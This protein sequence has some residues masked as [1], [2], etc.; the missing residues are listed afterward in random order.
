M[1]TLSTEAKEALAKLTSEELTA[2][3]LSRLEASGGSGGS[4]GNVQKVEVQVKPQAQQRKIRT[5]SGNK[6][7]SQGEVDFET[8][9][10]Q[11]KH[12]LDDDDLSPSDKKRLIENSLV[13]PAVSTIRGLSS[14]DAK[15]IVDTLFGIYGAVADGHELLLGFYGMLQE[16]EESASDYLERLYLYLL[17]CVDRG[18]LKLPEVPATL[19]IQ[20]IR[21]CPDE[22]MIKKLDLEKKIDNPPDFPDLFKDVRKEEARQTGKRL[23]LEMAT[24][25]KA[26]SAATVATPR[27]EELAAQLKKLKEENEKQMTQLKD[28]QESQFGQLMAKMNQM[29]CGSSSS[30][31]MDLTASHRHQP[32]YYPSGGHYQQEQHRPQRYDDQ[33]RPQQYDDQHRP[34]RYDGANGSQG[35]KWQKGG[36]FQH[37]SRGPR[38]GFCYKCGEDG[39]RAWDCRKESNPT[40]V[41]EKLLQNAKKAGTGPKQQQQGNKNGRP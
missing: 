36:K 38:R 26:Q 3:G 37:N 40:L 29:Q 41:Q 23:R 32:E 4:P 20:F 9:H 25:K 15:K 28:S 5:F 18:G 12:I 30:K 13:K 2:L 8:W 16:G 27:E 35:D 33:H 34:Q 31:Q 1:S 22:T 6:K 24:K 11:A 39:H 21:N 17:D 10:Y 19:L 7:L 14:P